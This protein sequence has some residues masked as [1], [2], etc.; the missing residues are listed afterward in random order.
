[1]EVGESLIYQPQI[2][3]DLYGYKYEIDMVLG[4]ADQFAK[5]DPAYNVFQVYGM[6]TGKSS[7]GEYTIDI[8]A[9]IYNETDVITQTESF[10]L[11]V[12]QIEDNSA[13]V[14]KPIATCQVNGDMYIKA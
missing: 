2:I 6:R 11:T 3:S 14:I 7:V 4:K 12:W 9:R 10:V 1:M 13:D 8:N 5:Y